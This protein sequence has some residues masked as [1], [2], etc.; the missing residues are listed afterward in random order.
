MGSPKALLDFDG[1]TALRLALEAAA[2]AGVGESV[3][4]LG[5]DADRI[6]ERE[7]L[8][9]LRIRAR[10]VR[11]LEEGSEQLRSLQIALAAIE[12]EAYDAFFVHPVD[13]PLAAASDYR[14]LLDAFRAGG[15]AT[16]RILSF[17]RRRGHPILC[18]RSV[19]P[20]ILALPGERTARDVIE[21][22][23][24]AYVTTPNA[25]VIEDMDTPEDHRRLV[26][27]YRARE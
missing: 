19:A 9:R 24:I 11:N 14:L 18:D 17:G 21:R 13:H 22:E 25:G 6:L 23:R 26:E 5:R 16:V 1:R 15:E 4:V 7:P 20:K 10:S 3:V 2:G 8:A 12:G 27:Q